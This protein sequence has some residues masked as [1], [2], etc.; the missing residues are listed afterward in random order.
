MAYDMPCETLR[1]AW[2]NRPPPV[3]FGEPDIGR[4]NP[5]GRVNDAAAK[6]AWPFSK[7]TNGAASA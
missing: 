2:R 5:V 6:S 4:V 7:V 3:P 1:F